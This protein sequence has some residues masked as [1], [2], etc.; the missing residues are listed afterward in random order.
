M[1]YEIPFLL[2]HDGIFT[3]T[4]HKQHLKNIIEE[5]TKKNIGIVLPFT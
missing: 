2:L 4:K 3:Q 5:V 1:K